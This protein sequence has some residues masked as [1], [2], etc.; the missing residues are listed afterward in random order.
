MAGNKV[1]KGNILLE[2][3]KPD[4]AKVEFEKGLKLIQDSGLSTQVKD[5][6]VL[7][8]HN[9]L[10]RAALAK[11]D[12]AGAKSEA[13]TFRKGAE[14]TKNPA[15]A[16]NAHGLDGQIAL[17]GKDFDRAVT[18]LSQANPQNPQ[19][20]YRL[21]QAYQGKGDTAK[22]AEFCGKAAGFNSLPAINYAFVRAKAKKAAAAS[23]AV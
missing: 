7:A 10:A 18:E 23:G 20:L 4:Q 15:Q 21:C 5:N 11:K 12:F 9:N 22:A 17:A 14:A 3:G 1:L 6:A 16:R 19:D 8:S 13:E 2:M